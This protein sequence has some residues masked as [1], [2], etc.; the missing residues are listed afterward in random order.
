MAGMRPS[1]KVPDSIFPPNPRLDAEMSP[2]ESG[3]VPVK[4]LLVKKTLRIRGKRPRDSGRV[5]F[6]RL[7]VKFEHFDKNAF[8]SSKFRRQHYFDSIHINSISE[9]LEVGDF[10]QAN[11]ALIVVIMTNSSRSYKVAWHFSLLEYFK[12]VHILLC[13]TSLNGR[14]GDIVYKH[15]QLVT[16]FVIAIA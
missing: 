16:Y 9:S 3:T 6:K 5:P 12:E 7:S 15:I 2:K 14:S 10:E 4:L 11:C 8:T 1:G 13:S